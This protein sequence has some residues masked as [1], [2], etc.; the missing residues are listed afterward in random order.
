MGRKVGRGGEEKEGREDGGEERGRERE[1]EVR[2]EREGR[3]AR[4]NRI[5]NGGKEKERRGRR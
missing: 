2:T 3:E 5:R 1:K 4:S